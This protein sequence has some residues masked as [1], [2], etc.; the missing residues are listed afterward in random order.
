MASTVGSGDPRVTSERET[1]YSLGR[2][3][4][5]QLA[6]KPIRSKS[7]EIRSP[8][9][10]FSRVFYRENMPWSP[11]F[12]QISPQEGEDVT[13]VRPI[14]VVTGNGC[15]SPSHGTRT[16]QNSPGHEGNPDELQSNQST[17]P[18]KHLRDRRGRNVP[19]SYHWL[20][21]LAQRPDTAESLLSAG[22][23]PV[24]PSRA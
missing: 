12:F 11:R 21:S 14:R 8:C 5:I 2:K 22:R 23:H 4:V 18:P 7:G 17:C 15:N 24:F 20:P 16:S 6:G 9:F 10:P 3:I 19:R 1:R 13:V